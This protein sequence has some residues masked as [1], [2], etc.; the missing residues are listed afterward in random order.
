[1]EIQKSNNTLNDNFVSDNNISDNNID[2]H[3]ELLRKM[4]HLSSLAIPVGYYFLDEYTA[5]WILLPLAIL[6]ICIDLSMKVYKP[7]KKVIVY[8][9]GPIMRPHELKDELVLNGATWVLISSSL[10]ILLMPKISFICGFVILIISDSAAAL[11]GRKFGKHPWFKNKS[12]EGSAA[13]FISAVISSG[14]I[15]L[16]I[17]ASWQYY[18]ALAIASLFA[19]FIE[20][21]SGALKIDDNISIP[22]SVALVI[23]LIDTLLSN[24]WAYQ[25]SSLM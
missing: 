10:C 3:N 4:I 13:F 22:F 14:I 1:M 5:F 12:I 24:V 23:F 19:S 7:L 11:I 9:F 8:I 18:V 20:A 25:I 21:I 15:G 17:S 6:A 2:Y 16:F